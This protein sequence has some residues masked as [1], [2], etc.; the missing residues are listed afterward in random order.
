MIKRSVIAITAILAMVS[1]SLLFAAQQIE[2]VRLHRAPDHT[3]VVFDLKGPLDHTLDKLANPDRIVV[4]LLDAEMDFDV[5]D[6][7]LETTPITGIRVGSHEGNRTRV[8]FDLSQAVRPRT[9][10]LKPIDPHGWRLVLDL[11]D[12]GQSEPVKS[13]A[14]A[15]SSSNVARPVIVAIDAGHGGEDPGASGPRG[16]REKDVVLQIARKLRD[17]LN[18]LSGLKAVMVRDGDY[19]VPLADR[20]RIA[21]EKLGADVFLSIHADAF[22]DKR[23]HGASVFALSLRGATSAR[24][25]LLADIANDSDRVAGVYQEEASNDQLLGVLADLT[26]EGSMTHSLTMGRL[27]L[28]EMARVTKLHGNRRKVEQ[29]GFAVL[30]QPEMVSLL[31]E[32]GF[33]SNPGEE[34]NLRDAGFQK[35]LARAIAAGVKSYCETYPKPGTWFAV[36]R[37]QGGSQASSHRIAPG[38][39]LSSIARR[40]AVSET[41]LR[42]HNKLDSDLIRVGQVLEIPR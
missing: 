24:A 5:A 10:V 27:V 36:Q 38:E 8:V 42:R 15:D 34:R 17:E 39:T 26:M 13:V 19:Y 28:E 11:F 14:P 4:D 23:A 1:S 37:S 41:A 29:A 18:G 21:R 33:I 7:S 40:Y 22:T 12:K 9:M 25:R 16:T 32:T 35:R 31:V 3:R 30:K 20:R 2:S 6:L